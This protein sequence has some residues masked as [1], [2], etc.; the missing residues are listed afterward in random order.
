MGPKDG[1][2]VSKQLFFTLVFVG[3]ETTFNFT[4][5]KTNHKSIWL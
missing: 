4:A 1:N 2:M 3:K 5:T